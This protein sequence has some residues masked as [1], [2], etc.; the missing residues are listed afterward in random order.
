MS[1]LL[2]FPTLRLHRWHLKN[3]QFNITSERT[4]PQSLELAMPR[5][6]RVKEGIAVK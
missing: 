6:G 2:P 3:V 4:A 1:A 5:A